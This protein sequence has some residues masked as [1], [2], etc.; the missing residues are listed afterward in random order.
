VADEDCESTED[1]VEVGLKECMRLLEEE[2]DEGLT[3]SDYDS[4]PTVKR[5]ITQEQEERT[6]PH[7]EK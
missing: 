1:V 6:V 2:G 4:R 7:E 5:I 3:Q